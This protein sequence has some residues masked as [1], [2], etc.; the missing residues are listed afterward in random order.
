MILSSLAG[1][2]RHVSFIHSLNKY[3][4]N[5]HY[6]PGPVQ[7]AGLRANP[8]HVAGAG[9]GGTGRGLHP[10]GLSLGQWFFGEVCV[11]VSELR[12][13]KK[14]SCRYCFLCLHD[15]YK[16]GMKLLCFSI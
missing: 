2:G 14:G 6:A 9:D 16:E 5:I 13:T 15:P 4:L 3:L 7:G 1:F 12:R 8:W 10:L 11:C